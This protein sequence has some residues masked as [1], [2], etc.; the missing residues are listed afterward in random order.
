MP[1]AGVRTRL[2]RDFSSPVYPRPHLRGWATVDIRGRGQ[3]VR[4]MPMPAWCRRR[5]TIGHHCRTAVARVFRIRPRILRCISHVPPGGPVFA[6]PG[7]AKE[8]EPAVCP[9]VLTLDMLID[10]HG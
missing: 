4:T 7:H 2:E 8:Q 3:R 10:S 9:S 1:L 6:P 5:C